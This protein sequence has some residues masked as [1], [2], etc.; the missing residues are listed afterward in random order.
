MRFYGSLKD[1]NT[2]VIEEDFKH[3]KVR[4]VS[5]NEKFEVIDKTTFK[6]YYCQ[7]KKI[8]RK[9]VICTIIGEKEPNLPKVYIALFQSIPIQISLMD[10]IVEK[11]TQIGVSLLVPLI[12]RRSLQNK[13]AIVKRTERW[14]RISRET[15][16]QCERD[17]PLEISPP[18]S[19]T[20][21][22]KA[23]K[24]IFK[25]KA[26]FLKLVAYEREEFS[27]NILK[28]REKFPEIKNFALVLGP[29]GGFT[30][31]EIKYLKEKDFK[32]FS[33]GNFILTTETAATVSTA[34]VYNLW[35]F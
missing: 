31:E 19:F 7:L 18:I 27:N 35:S 16:K 23:I 13:E 15:L 4:R 28:L 8:E 12:T 14:K 11:I 25:D 26:P 34:L 10:E 33:L 9:R 1:K 29:E 20:E 21:V 6:V 32:S 5:Q 30:P 2:I 17:V 22:E 3:F 24:E